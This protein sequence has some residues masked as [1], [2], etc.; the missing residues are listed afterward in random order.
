MTWLEPQYWS[1]GTWYHIFGVWDPGDN[2]KIYVNGTLEGTTPVPTTTLR[3]STLGL[4]IGEMQGPR[5]EGLIADAQV[6]NTA[7]NASQ[8]GALYTNPGSVTSG[9]VGYWPLSSAASVPDFSGQGNTAT[10]NGA[11]TN[12]SAPPVTILN[13]RSQCGHPHSAQRLDSR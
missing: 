8:I 3:D 2:I 10:N 13:T 1:A 4:R 6:F 5:F 7:L 12:A 9:L 11:T